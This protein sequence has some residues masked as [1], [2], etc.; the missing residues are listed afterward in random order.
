MV[1]HPLSYIRSPAIVNMRLTIVPQV[2]PR[3]ND[4]SVAKDS[5]DRELRRPSTPSLP[6]ATGLKLMCQ[7]LEL[8]ITE[9]LTLSAH[10][11]PELH[12]KEI[13]LFARCFPAGILESNAT[14]S[15]KPP[16]SPPLRLPLLFR[17]CRPIP[18]IPKRLLQFP[19]PL[20]QPPLA[21]TPQATQPFHKAPF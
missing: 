9:T 19:H 7:M 1:R 17:P 16:I 11:I 18:S 14:L 2:L 3:F 4:L 10:L 21:Q 20:P 8:F 12:V 5:A 6:S 15:S 13:H